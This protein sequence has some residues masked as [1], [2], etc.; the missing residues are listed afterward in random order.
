[1]DRKKLE[2]SRFRD[3]SLGIILVLF[4][5][6]VIVTQVFGNSVGNEPDNISSAGSVSFNVYNE[7]TFLS[8]ESTSLTGNFESPSPLPHIIP[9]GSYYNFQVNTAVFKK[10]TGTAVYRVNIPTGSYTTV[11][12]KM[13]LY[14]G[15][16]SSTDV[17]ISSDF[18]DSSSRHND[19]TIF[20]SL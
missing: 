7:I 12:I 10:T 1:M 6:L 8:M 16:Y 17:S 15:P 5:L 14:G 13:N 2:I 4:I 9:P 11:T 18:L 19:I 3:S 20:R